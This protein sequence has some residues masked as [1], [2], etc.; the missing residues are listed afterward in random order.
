MLHSNLGQFAD[1]WNYGVRRAYVIG[2]SEYRHPLSKLTTP[3][4]DANAIADVLENQHGYVTHRLCSGIV[5]LSEIESLLTKMKAEVKIDDRVVLYFA[6]HGVPPDIDVSKA[7]YLLPE[8]ALRNNPSTFIAMDDLYNQLSGLP[9]RH[10]L[11]I[12]DCCFAGSFRWARTRPTRELG[13]LPEEQLYLE[14]FHRFLGRRAWQLLTSTGSTELAADILFGQREHSDNK[15]HSPF[16]AALLAGLK[17]EADYRVRNGKAVR[18]GV[19]TLRK[20]VDYLSDKMVQVSGSQTVGYYPLDQHDDGEFLFLPPDNDKQALYLPSVRPVLEKHNPYLGLDAYD[21]IGERARHLYGRDEAR[22]KLGAFVCSRSLTVF[23][24]ASGTGKSSL[25]RAGLMPDLAKLPDW[26]VVPP[27]RVGGTPLANLKQILAQEESPFHIYNDLV[28]SD[29]SEFAEYLH[30]WSQGFGLN[31]H[32]LLCVDQFEDLITQAVSEEEQAN[33]CKLLEHTLEISNVHLVL[34]LRSDYERYF[35]TDTEI[36][37]F[38]PAFINKWTEARFPIPVM[39]DEELRSVIRGPANECALAVEQGIV[40]I[41]IRE[42]GG[43][44][45]R[46]PLLAATLEQLYDGCVKRIDFLNPVEWQISVADYQLIGGIEKAVISRFEEVYDKIS[47]FEKELVHTLRRVLLRLVTQDGYKISK[48]QVPKSEFNFDL[49]TEVGRLEAL[50]ST[51]ILQVLA[52]AR[53][54]V[55]DIRPIHTGEHEEIVELIHDVVVQ[56]WQVL[57]DWIDQANKVM[58]I[59]LRRRLSQDEVRWRSRATDG[60]NQ[61]DQYNWSNNP[62]L[63]TAEQVLTLEPLDFNEAETAFIQISRRH[64]KILGRRTGARISLVAFLVL[65]FISASSFFYSQAKS[66]GLEAKSRQVSAQAEMIRTTQPNIAAILSAHSTHLKQ[67]TQARSAVLRTALQDPRLL[68]SLAGQQGDVEHLEFSSDG[69]MLV[70]ATSSSDEPN[71][72]QLTIWNVHSGKVVATHRYSGQVK[73]LA[74]SSDLRH[75]AVILANNTLRLLKL[76]TEHNQDLNYT[77]WQ[78]FEDGF[79]FDSKMQFSQDGQYLFVSNGHQ[80]W[81]L[82]ITSQSQS[83][84]RLKG[85]LKDTSINLIIDGNNKSLYTGGNDGRVLQHNLVTN[86]HQDIYKHGS[87]VTALAFDA[88]SKSLAVGRGNGQITVYVSTE[89]RTMLIR[90]SDGHP[91]NKIKLSRGGSLLA[92][93]MNDL[94]QSEQL[95]IWRIPEY[96]HPIPVEAPSVLHDFAFSRDGQYFAVAGIHSYLHIYQIADG[97]KLDESLFG[98]AQQVYKVTFSPENPSLF[99]SSGDGGRVMLWDMARNL[100]LSESVEALAFSPVDE[101]IAGGGS[102]G[103][104]FIRSPT[105][106]DTKVWKVPDQ[107]QIFRQIL[108]SPNGQVLAAGGETD[109]LVLFDRWKDRE[110]RFVALESNIKAMLFSADSSILHTVDMTSNHRILSVSDGKVIEETPLKPD[111]NA[112]YASLITAAFS[113]D[114]DGVALGYLNGDVFISRLDGSKPVKLLHYDKMISALAYSNDGTV[115][116]SA[117]ENT[118][119]LTDIRTKKPLAL[120]L[121]DYQSA[122]DSLAISPSG[123]LIAAGCVDGTI[124]LFDMMSREQLGTIKAHTGAVFSLTFHPREERLLSG[125]EDQK[126]YLWDLNFDNFLRRNREMAGRNLSAAEWEQYIGL[127]IP[128]ERTFLEFPDGEGV[129]PKMKEHPGVSERWFVLGCILAWIPLMLSF[130]WVEFRNSTKHLVRFSLH[131]AV[132]AFLLAGVFLPIELIPGMLTLHIDWGIRFILLVLLTILSVWAQRYLELHPNWQSSRK[133]SMQSGF[134]E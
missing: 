86:T 10:L 65:L 35:V 28:N 56:E 103:M 29:P 89:G 99:A 70:A 133:E 107:N 79:G 4:D 102:E 55:T 91:V 110:P 47:S 45:W 62:D 3:R 64:R 129:S 85:N 83:L 81:Q 50:R 112:E 73:S 12:L 122:V 71:S 24:G 16:A 87:P 119:R 84:S 78:P 100:K 118:V 43:Q 68:Y 69:T 72:G 75:I 98:H 51:N 41:L 40:D 1:H 58:P 2:A 97:V 106:Q 14:R 15:A 37:R 125:G 116:A 128:Y 92:A 27:I 11:I 96:A 127:D 17:G 7:G 82:N 22:R 32:L 88:E 39:S 80:V 5:G 117:G 46:L 104:L 108:F 111:D 60:T 67:I 19:I 31:K 76:A 61:T 114:G 54:I 8:T 120:L 48:R 113:N 131:F 94:R 52:D 13:E 33:F 6:G 134:N 42:V 57:T 49:N 20:L 74:I 59:S 23:T 109:G 44:P 95:K 36:G 90:K 63:S 115:L 30:K 26:I 105:K 18:D 9:C 21:Y 66:L 132:L 93:E 25:I 121:Y 126:S 53:L 123:Q 77:D 130:P 34:T 101:T 124:I 38:S